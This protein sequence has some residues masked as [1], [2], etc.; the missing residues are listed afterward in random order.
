[1]VVTSFVAQRDD[2][3]DRHR[4]PRRDYGGGGGRREHRRRADIRHR[5]E[6]AQA[7]EKA[8][9]RLAGR[10]RENGS[11]G[12]SASRAVRVLPNSAATTWARRAPSAT[13]MPISLSVLRRDS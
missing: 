1:M 9:K 12:Q 3:V 5:I 10:K 11:D 6:R 2:R 8:A 7:V 4:T 13:R